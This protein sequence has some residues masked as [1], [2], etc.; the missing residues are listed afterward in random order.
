MQD[1]VYATFIKFEAYA[2]ELA[3]KMLI[4]KNAR[5]SSELEPDTDNA[6]EEGSSSQLE[7]SLTQIIKITQL[8]FERINMLQETVRSNMETSFENLAMHLGLVAS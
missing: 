4:L 3:A 6:W 5:N 2:K 8:N 7:E 1:N